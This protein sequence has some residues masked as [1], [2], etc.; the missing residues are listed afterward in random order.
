MEY[1]KSRPVHKNYSLWTFAEQG[2]ESHDS[3]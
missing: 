2:A 3:R 1:A